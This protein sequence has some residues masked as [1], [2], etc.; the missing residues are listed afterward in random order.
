[1]KRRRE[2][3]SQHS[4]QFNNVLNSIQNGHQS[5]DQIQ[6]HQ[7]KNSG[8]EAGDSLNVSNMQSDINLTNAQSIGPYGNFSPKNRATNQGNNGRWAS[9]PKNSQ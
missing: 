9:R 4:Y 3:E 6:F 5:V 2:D 7:L 1:M 8:M